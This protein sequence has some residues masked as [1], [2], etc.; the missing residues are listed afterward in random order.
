MPE[1]FIKIGD[2]KLSTFIKPLLQILML[3]MGATMTAQDFVE[4]FKTP[5][6]VF[7]GLLC[8]FLIM[9]GLGFLLSRSF[10]FEPEVAAGIV[11]IGCSPSGLASN[12]MAM[13]AKANLALSI[14]ITST[15]TLLAPIFTPLLMKLLGG[16]LIELDFFKMFI[17]MCLLV[18]VPVILGVLLN[19]FLPKFVKSIQHILPY[20][21]MAAIAFIILVVT[22]SGNASLKTIGSMLIIVT[23][24]HNLGGYL[25]GYYSAKALKLN[26]AD[27]R[28]IALE[29]GM[30]NAGLAS[31]LANEMGKIATVGL[32]SA[33]FGPFMNISGSILA[34]F[35]GKEKGKS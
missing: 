15:A 28:A 13:M 27:A 10:N 29:V 8:Q 33:I 1:P 2:T 5:K 11:L 26:E 7:I 6:K 3:G 12:V 20:F 4:I 19:R 35:W 22:A 9:P 21:S 23:A 17:E 34:N 24:I 30:Q 18:L 31:A 32:A 16:S 25:L 14:T